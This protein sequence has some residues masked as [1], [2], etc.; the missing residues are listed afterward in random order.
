[1]N[2]LA[3]IL[4][5][6]P[7]AAPVP[8]FPKLAEMRARTSAAAAERLD[9][10]V[11]GH[12]RT[13]VPIEMLSIGEGPYAA[14]L[15][16]APHPNEPIGCLAI[17]H[18]I[19]S[20]CGSVALRR[21]LPVRWH[22]IKAIEPDALRL[23]EGWFDRPCDLHA[24]LRGFFRP[25]LCD[26]SEYG[27]PFDGLVNH[28][29][30]RTPE[31]DA[32]RAAISLAR[33]DL[34]YSLHN[35]DYGGAHYILSDPVP[36]IVHALEAQP[37]RYGLPMKTQAGP[38][39]THLPYAPG[40]FP[41]FDVVAV[42]R[43]DQAAHG[44]VSSWSGGDS[45]TDYAA[46]RGAFTLIA[47]MTFWNWGG[48]RAPVGGGFS[49]RQLQLLRQSADD[50]IVGLGG[51]VIDCYS[52]APQM[53]DPLIY[54]AAQEI[55]LHA[56][57]RQA[58][59]AL[60]DASLSPGGADSIHRYLDNRINSLRHLSL[61]SRLGCKA[62]AGG[63]LNAA[64]AALDARVRAEADTLLTDFDLDPVSLQAGVQAQAEAAIV[65]AH[66]ITQRGRPYWSDT[67]PSV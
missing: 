8:R 9:V 10:Q 64:V 45:A 35:A 37:A 15:V 12:S 3:E 42:V 6:L 29:V 36:G 22:F 23:N 17:E 60:R 55:L 61:I 33:P 26:Q 51:T 48:R 2:S 39:A 50:E 38:F 18:L 25:A 19:D 27:F 65:A 5:L 62:V 63:K 1:M 67:L 11:V 16:G 41:P 53:A 40:V 58:N 66:A 47:E 52:E 14:L 13:G 28:A 31:N 24:Y 4:D 54:R 44:G 49:E 56:K 30:A 46:R 34:L 43:Q 59:L 20:L 57:A 7:M 32:Y 21:A